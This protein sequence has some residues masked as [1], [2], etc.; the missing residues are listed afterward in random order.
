MNYES[1]HINRLKMIRL[2]E[3]YVILNS[4]KKKITLYGWKR[5][6]NVSVLLTITLQVRKN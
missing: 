1:K 4:S 3:Q 6:N 5:S 2:K